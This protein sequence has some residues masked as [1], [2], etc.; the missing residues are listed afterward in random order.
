MQY[1]RGSRR[2]SQQNVIYR[3]Q[4]C[5]MGHR[6]ITLIR[7]AQLLAPSGSETLDGIASW[8]TTKLH[9]PAALWAVTAGHT[10]IRPARLTV[11]ISPRLRI[12]SHSIQ[13]DERIPSS[14]QVG[15][16]VGSA[17]WT[18][19]TSLLIAPSQKGYCHYVEYN[20]FWFVP[21][22]HNYVLCLMVYKAQPHDW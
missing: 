22:A 13:H 6:S 16:P 4:N 12:L 21:P 9:H 2:S 10:S 15:K 20:T 19:T 3:C 17:D 18:T 11:L 1:D 14:F 8:C 5:P 7:P